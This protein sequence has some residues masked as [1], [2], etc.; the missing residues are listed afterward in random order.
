[1]S[2]YYFGIIAAIVLA[3]IAICVCI[4]KTLQRDDDAESILQRILFVT[5][6]AFEEEAREL[7]KAYSEERRMIQWVEELANKGE[8]NIDSLA[9][10]AEKRAYALGV[11]KAEDSVVIAETALAKCRREISEEQSKLFEYLRT[12]LD[13]H[14]DRSKKALKELVLQEKILKERLSAARMEL[15]KLKMDGF[16]TEPVVAKSDDK[17]TILSKN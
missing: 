17:I 3:A 1:M 8:L 4:V 2:A 9:S 7:T 14:A 6:R 11:K 15:Q 13:G 12:N 5:H 10:D 16:K